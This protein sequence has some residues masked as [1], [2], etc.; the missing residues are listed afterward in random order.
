M[1]YEKRCS[2]DHFDRDIVK[3][4]L[5]WGPLGM[6]RDEDVFPAFGMNVTQFRRRFAQIAN[7]RDITAFDDADQDLLNNAR[8]YLAQGVGES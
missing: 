5:L 2:I 1:M 4:M 8:H 7:R 6:L 3:H